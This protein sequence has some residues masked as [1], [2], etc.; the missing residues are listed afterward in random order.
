MNSIDLHIAKKKLRIKSVNSQ[1]A[2]FTTVWHGEV[3]M[4]DFD[5]VTNKIIR[6]NCFR[7]IDEGE[8]EQLESVLRE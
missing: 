7:T 3:V 5:L 2:F 6:I 8:I 1:S 4:G